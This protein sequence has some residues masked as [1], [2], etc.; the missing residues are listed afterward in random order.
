MVEG[1]KIAAFCQM[2]SSLLKSDNAEG[3]RILA[4]LHFI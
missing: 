3:H 4:K 1:H 2:H